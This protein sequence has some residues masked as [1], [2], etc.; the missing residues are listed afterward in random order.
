M[1]NFATI[2]QEKVKGAESFNGRIGHNNRSFFSDN[3]NQDLT[4]KNIIIQDSKYKNFDDFCATKKE[5]IKNYNFENGTKHRFI[6]STLNKKTKE[7]E[8]GAMSQ[9]FVISLSPDFLTEEESIEYLKDADNFLRSV[10]PNCEVIQSIIHLDEKTP[11]LHFNVSYF[12]ETEKRFMQKELSQENRTDINSIREAFQKS[13]AEKYNLKKQDGSVVENH[14]NK[15]SLKVQELKE[16]EKILLKNVD[17]LVRMETLEVDKINDVSTKIEDDIESIMTNAKTFFGVNKDKL[18]DSVRQTLQDYS[19]I[20]FKS[21]QEQK[22]IKRG[23]VLQ[24]ENNELVDKYNELVEDF[25]QIQ[26]ENEELKED[27]ILLQDENSSLVN[28]TYTLK[29]DIK[30]LETDFKFNYKSWKENRKSRYEKMMENSEISRN[31]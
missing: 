17:E 14:E 20:D 8:L 18:I 24:N 21:L 28:E 30:D 4:H 15:A 19:K 29:S 5:E 11:H 10:Y 23:N 25:N 2:R 26:N 31:R 3:I 27:N 1:S 12:H 22:A 13:V 16:K 9:E 7:Y 6:R